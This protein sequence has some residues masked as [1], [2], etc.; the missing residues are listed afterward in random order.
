MCSSPRPSALSILSRACPASTVLSV[1]M[2]GISTRLNFVMLA[3][4]S[5]RCFSES[6][7]GFLAWGTR[8]ATLRFSVRH[9]MDGVDIATKNER[10][11]RTAMVMGARAS[12]EDSIAVIFQL[13]HQM[14]EKKPHLSLG[15]QSR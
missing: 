6:E 2:A 14:R 11:R 5:A 13:Y 10:V 1:L 7:R 15:N 12:D 3:S 9:S 8:S 4:R